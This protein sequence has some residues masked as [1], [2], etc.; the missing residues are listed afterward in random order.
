MPS[1][2]ATLFTLAIGALT[3][4]TPRAGV[5]QVVARASSRPPG[6]GTAWVIDPTRSTMAFRIQ[7]LISQVNGS[8][9]RWSGT[10]VTQDHDW[11][12]GTV[13]VKAHVASVTT[14]NAVR[15]DDL[16]STAFFAADSFPDLEFESTGIVATDSALEIGGI[17]TL[18]GRSRHVVLAG[19]W[20]GFEQDPDGNEWVSFKAHTGISRRAFDIG[21]DE[22]IGG[23][24]VVDDSVAIF[25]EAWAIRA[26]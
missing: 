20:R 18:K 8:F 23:R 25:I 19:Q 9:T 10:I 6:A 4:P 3:L 14:G 5:A 1:K 26:R 13:N 21:W 11:S 22:R 24:P 15:D 7:H 17:L 12:H 16:R 2:R